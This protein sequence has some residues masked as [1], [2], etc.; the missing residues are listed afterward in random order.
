MRCFSKEFGHSYE[1]YSFGYCNY[2]VREQADVLSAIY[3]AGYLPYSNDLAVRDTF[4]M[5]RS[6]RIPLKEFELTSENRRIAKKYDSAFSKERVVASTFNTT[7]PT[8]LSF[9]LEYFT[10]LHGAAMSKDR[11]EF[12]LSLNLISHIVVYKKDDAVVAYVFEVSGG[13]MTHFWYSFYDLSYVQQSLGLWLMLDSIRGA[14][15]ANREH[16][17][18]GTAYG[19]KGLYKTNFS[20]LEFWDGTIWSKDLQQLKHLCR[21][22]SIRHMT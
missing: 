14:Q 11:L 8:F 13:H 17:Y 6:T 1:T 4:Y 15:I 7:N 21:N 3:E 18:L 2:A 10:I 19:E 22:D 16:F 9:C 5:A 20:P 12:I